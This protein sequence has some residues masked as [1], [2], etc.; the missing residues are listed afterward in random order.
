M[1][2][3]DIDFQPEGVF[4]SAHHA[5]ANN[6]RQRRR[7]SPRLTRVVTGTMKSGRESPLRLIYRRRL[8]GSAPLRRRPFVSVGIRQS[9]KESAAHSS[10]SVLSKTRRGKGNVLP[11]FRRSS[12][13]ESRPT[14]KRKGE[15]KSRRQNCSLPPLHDLACCG[16]IMSAGGSKSRKAEGRKRGREEG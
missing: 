8:S 15:W 3:E 16:G 5:R 14:K 11:Q 13:S 6:Q 1:R 7:S 4:R 9:L 2:H 12:I 10:T